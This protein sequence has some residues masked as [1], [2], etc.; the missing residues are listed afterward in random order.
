MT[1]GITYAL[2]CVPDRQPPTED[3]EARKSPLGGK[4]GEECHGAALR[5]PAE[6]NAVR[7]NACVNLGGDELVEAVHGL[8]HA[9]LVFARVDVAEL[10]DVEP[11][12]SF[13]TSG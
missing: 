11:V 9:R 3:G 10:E 13:R 6:Y 8:E 1:E 12:R 4:S 5:E 2:Y 7:R